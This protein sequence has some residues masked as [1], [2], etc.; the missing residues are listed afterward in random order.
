M[1]KS[2]ITS[3][4]HASAAHALAQAELWDGL[5]P[6]LRELLETEITIPQRCCR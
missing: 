5:A 6:S 3:D 1:V 2:I 4:D